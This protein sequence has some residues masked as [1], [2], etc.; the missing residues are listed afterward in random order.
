MIAILQCL[1][2]L[3]LQQNTKKKTQQQKHEMYFLKTNYFLLEFFSENIIKQQN[4]YKSKF[5]IIFYWECQPRYSLS[6]RLFRTEFTRRKI[7]SR[8]DIYY[9]KR[10]LPPKTIKWNDKK[11]SNST[12]RKR[13]DIYINT[14]TQHKIFTF[15]LLVLFYLSFSVFLGNF[16][17]INNFSVDRGSSGLKHWLDF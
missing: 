1:S 2:L 13:R 14:R 7:K 9:F 6:V 10:F 5:Y 17:F 15:I 12:T 8:T 16:R 3:T 11:I 4:I